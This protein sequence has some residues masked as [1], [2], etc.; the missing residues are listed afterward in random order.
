[1]LEMGNA[2]PQPAGATLQAKLDQGRA[3]HR[4]G[5]LADAEICYVEV[6][7]QRPDHFAALRLLGVI[8]L[9][10]RQ[11]ER[12]VEL[13]Q[14]AIVLNP[15]VAEAHNN[16][17]IG[18]KDLKR[19]LEA[20]AS[21]DK[22]I[23]LKPDYTDAHYNRGNALMELK[24]LGEALASY[25]KAIALKPDFAV[26]H[27]NRGNALMDLNRPAE[28]LASYDR[29]IGL[30]PDITEAH[31]N[32]GNALRDLKRPAEALASYERAIALKSDYA[33]AHNN[34]G[35]ALM[36]LKRPAEALASYDKA[37]ALKP[38]YAE[39][40]NSRGN[41]LMDL[42]RPEEALASYDKAIALKPDYAG[43]YNNRGNALNALGLRE[44]AL[45]SY[46]RAIAL[47]PE[48]EFLHGN[49]IFMK[50][51]ICDWSNLQSEI[52]QLAHKIDRAAKVAQPIILLTGTNFPGLQRK[53]AEIYAH[54]R[55]PLNIALSKIGKRQRRNK[56]RIGYFSGEFRNHATAF[57]TTELFE[58]HNRSQFDVIGFSFGMD[59]GGD[60][61]RRLEAAFDKFIDVRTRSDRDVALLARNLEIDIAV[62]LGG[63]TTDS[64]TKVFSMRA[65]P[66]QVSY[67]GYPSTMGAEYIDYLI[68]DPTLIPEA[69]KRYY[70]EKIVYLPDTYQVNDSS[71]GIADKAFTRAEVGLPQEGFVFCCFNN[72]YKITPEVFDCWMRILKQVDGS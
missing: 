42:K 37:I 43:A 10:T 70:A 21:Y 48:F 36:D 66:V 39:A 62:D 49:L 51:M 2:Q 60:I 13:I 72:N 30:T 22:A 26:A 34:R 14:K 50:M 5:K 53:A 67:L 4:Q 61:R 54:A 7:Q 20:L 31:G 24:R 17:G 46:E 15:N 55:Y 25:D 19:L 57:L 63:F 68:A 16:L 47:K 3:L 12:G 41:A 1:M 32:R 33:E 52:A 38:D 28:A 64:R 27:N 40:H 69:E 6:L 58:Q 59:T 9:Q 45:A 56:I 8:A 71:R 23:A 29:V 35:N 18:L 11:T 65:A 44:Q